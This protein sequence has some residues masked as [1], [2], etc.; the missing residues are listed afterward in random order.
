MDLRLKLKL[1][2]VKK[3]IYGEYAQGVWVALQDLIRNK[4]EIST[5]N[6]SIAML[7]KY[8]RVCQDYYPVLYKYLKKEHNKTRGIFDFGIFRIPEPEVKDFGPFIL[9]FVDLIFPHIFPLNRYTS[10]LQIEGDYEKFGIKVGDGDIVVDAGASMGFFSVYA[11]SKGAHVYAFEPTPSSLKYLYETDR[12][13]RTLSGKI[14]VIPWAI[15]DR[16]GTFKFTISETYIAAASAILKSDGKMVEVEGISLDEWAVEQKI[17]R[18]DFIKA[19]I[20]GAERNLLCGAT[21]ILREFK[22]KLAICTYHLKDDPE[23]LENMILAAN[24]KYKV[25]HSSHKL[26]AQ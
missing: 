26:F 7:S 1:D 20:E 21:R 4:D 14:T 24:P 16:K 23:V 3:R 18:I 13:N 2:S 22:P 12:L 9:E 5:L 17:P 11:A 15:M 10:Y 25:N 6:F 19:D 8:F